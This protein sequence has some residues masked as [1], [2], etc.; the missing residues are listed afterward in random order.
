LAAVTDST[1]YGWF[2][3]GYLGYVGTFVSS[4]VNRMTFATDTAALSGRGP[5]TLARQ[6]L[7]AACDSTNGWFGG[8]YLNGG[9]GNSSTVDRITYATDTA[10]ASV[11]GPLIQ[12]TNGTSSTSGVQ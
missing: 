3:G 4:I 2:G 5:L 7:S 12:A 8:G 10:T 9:G 6:L 1:T 11:R